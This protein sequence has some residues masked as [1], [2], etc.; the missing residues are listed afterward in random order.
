MQ[1]NLVQQFANTAEGQEAESILRACVHCGFCTATCPTY[2]ELNDERDGPRGRIYLMKMFLEG[3]EVTEKSREHLDRCLTCRSC[4]TTCPSGVKYGRLLDISR[5]LMEQEMPRPPKERWIRWSLAR[6]LPNR[7]LFGLLLRM[8]QLFRP[9]LPGK[10]RTKVPPRKQASPWPAAS[11]ERI[12]L[13]L[14][15]CV[16]PSAT[17]NT[18][19]AAAR[20]LDRL[21]ISMVEAP[22]AGCCG[23]VNHHLSEHEKALEAMRRNI[24]AWWPAIDAGAE[25]IIMTAS[26]CGAMVQEYGHLL[27]GDPVYAAKAQKVSELTIDLGAFL[28]KQDLEKLDVPKG[29]GKVAFHCPCTLQHAMQQSGVV[30]QVL[31]K[32]GIELADTKE[33]HLCC[34]SAGTYSILQPEL[35]QRLLNNKLKALTVDSPDRI[36]TANIGCQMHLE[37]KAKVPVQHWIELLDA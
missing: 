34:G 32:A 1:T 31:R 13:A 9:V 33:K 20:V 10:L 22:E 18:N 16:Q 4:E 14:A 6:V 27:K 29:A 35:S 17:P 23:A 36:V 5:G 24:D 26:G 19:A 7:Q 11:H 30:D 21:G 3:E 28:L 12:V 2:Q 37:T 8:G 25:A 15:G